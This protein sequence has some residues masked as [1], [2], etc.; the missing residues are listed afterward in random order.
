MPRRSIALSAVIVTALAVTLAT[1]AQGTDE[2]GARVVRFTIASPLVHATM[3]VAAVVPAG[4]TTGP[5]PL[6]VFLHGYGANQD[7]Y[8][9]DAMFAAL[10]RLG[11]AAPD[12]VFPY[13]GPDSYWHDRA[14]GKWGSYVMDEVIPQALARLHADPRRVAI[15]G[16]SMGGFGALDIARLQ[17]GR[18]CAVG[19]H[20]PARSGSRA[21]RAPPRRVRRR[22]GLRASRRD[23]GGG[24]YRH[25]R[26]RRQSPVWLDVGTQ[27]PFR[28]ADTVLAGLLLRSH[29]QPLLLPRLAGRSRRRLL[30]QPLGELSR[31]LRG[32]ARPLPRHPN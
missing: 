14:D 19:G 7:S 22:R 3:P 32:G 18:F 8:L 6:L 21:G 28:S 11:A 9:T 17:P 26:G 15:G 1:R 16:I 12:V 25:D 5:R 20:S 4:S 10:A 29:G 30:G 13:G 31:V 24:A 23:R 2:R 27:D